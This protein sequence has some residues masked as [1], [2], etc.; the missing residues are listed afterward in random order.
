MRGVDFE[1]ECIRQGV[2]RHSFWAYLSYPP[3]LKRVAPSGYAFTE[4]KVDPAGVAH[5]SCKVLTKP[6]LQDH[7]RTRDGAIWLGLG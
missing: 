5:L 4:A 2:N 6:A 1:D 3:L 7:G